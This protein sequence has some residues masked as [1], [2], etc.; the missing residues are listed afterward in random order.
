M[1]TTLITRTLTALL[2]L[3]VLQSCVKEGFEGDLPEG[4]GDPSVVDMIDLQIPEGFVFETSQQV[5]V[6]IADAG[7]GVIYDVYAYNSDMYQGEELQIV[8]DEG[9][10]ETVSEYRSDVLNHFLFRGAPVNGV[11]AQTVVLPAYYEKLY[12]R[13]KEGTRYQSRIVEISAGMA[14]VNFDTEKNRGGAAKVVVDMLYSVN[15]S[16]QLFTVEPLNGE[17]TTLA[18]MPMGSYTAAI[19]H[20][21]LALYSIGKSN[22]FPL[23]KYD[24]ISDTWSTVGNLG[25]GGPRLDYNEVDGLLYFSTNATVYSIDPTNA[26]VLSSWQIQGLHNTGGGDLAFAEDGTLFLCT[27][28][29][30]YRLEMDENNVY[31]ATRISADNLPFQPTSMTFDSNNELWL[32]NN[33]GNSDLI[34][35]DT[36]TGG[37][38]YVYGPNSDSVAFGRTINDLT[39]YTVSDEEIEDPDS[40]ND[41]IPDSEDLYPEEAD[42]A[43][44]TYTP[45]KYGWGTVAFEDL[46]PYLGDY[47][48]NDTAVNY[49]FVAI[50]NSQNQ[51]V[52]LDIHYELTS[53]G[54]GLVN[55]FGIE[56][57]NLTP[58]QISSVTGTHIT[59]DYITNSANGTEAGQSRAVLILFDDNNRGVNV[60]RKAEVVLTTPI[61]TEELGVAPFNPFLIIG[62]N[63]AKEVHLPDYNPTDLG[64]SVFEVAGI[65]R[66]PDGNY[67]TDSGLPWAINIIHNFAV[68]KEGVPVNQAYNHFNAWATSGGSSV[69]DWYKDNPGYRNS[70]MLKSE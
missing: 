62:E 49:R 39:T 1:D 30:L 9:L 42:K 54:A 47:D 40:D 44:E 34:I 55:G 14:S 25:M 19:D 61:T 35:M 45:S 12:V 64:Q 46:W 36:V 58:N 2:A 37:Y 70:N 31:Q 29:G 11:L 53:D 17:M 24:M 26:T 6:Q 5:I 56:I 22:P 50:L 68:P 10:P 15:G 3:A 32:A 69:T 65:S 23:M 41:G 27:F 21:N 33:S 60:A 7:Q 52:Q 51:V 59:S 48:F 20:A 38:E 4:S 67:K 13:R 63:R 8:N 18:T 66:D 28:S 16:G 57:G 43:F